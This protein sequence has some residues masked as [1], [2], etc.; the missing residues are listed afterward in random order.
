VGFAFIPFVGTVA[1][2]IL[3]LVWSAVLGAFS[4]VVVAVSYRQLRVAKEGV[5]IEQIAAVFD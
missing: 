5:D 2:S 1:G 3:T 4:S